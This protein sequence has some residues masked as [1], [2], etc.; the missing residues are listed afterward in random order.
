MNERNIV[1]NIY[2]ASPDTS[3]TGVI[4][5]LLIFDKMYPS[6]E[7][8]CTFKSQVCLNF[9]NWIQHFSPNYKTQHIL[10]HD[11]VD[12]CPV[13][14]GAYVSSLHRCICAKAQP[15]FYKSSLKA[16]YHSEM[17]WKNRMNGTGS[18]IL[19]PLNASSRMTYC[20]RCQAMETGSNRF[21][22]IFTSRKGRHG[23]AQ[24]EAS[25]YF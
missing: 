2:L 21:S 20:H 9:S 3:F 1:E 12:L 14:F 24:N 23:I 11:F 18:D 5:I 10:P 4:Y 25:V 8:E 13:L 7:N 16:K 17:W 15:F 22:V 6:F 19:S